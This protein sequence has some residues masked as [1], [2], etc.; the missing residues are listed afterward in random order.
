VTRF[1]MTWLEV[2]AQSPLGGNLHVVIHDADLLSGSTMQAAARR[3]RLSET[4][5]VCR[6]SLEGADYRHRI[7]TVT[8]ELPFA[9]HPS[10]GTAAAVAKRAG[11]GATSLVQETGYGLQR[12]D[13]SLAETGEDALVA[14]HQGQPNLLEEVTEVAPL[15]ES[16]GLDLQD[17]HPDLGPQVISTGLATLVAPVRD[18]ATLGRITPRLVELAAVL[19]GLESH[20]V[21]C[22]VVVMA[23]RYEAKNGPGAHW[24]ARC[25]TPAVASGEDSAT[26]SAAGPLTAYSETHLGTGSI[27]IEQGVEM[28]SPSRLYGRM[29]SGS[30]VV[31]GQARFVGQGW[32][33]LP[34]AR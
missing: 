16:L 8:S 23:E 26:G 5:F 30:V 3:F 11:N 21:T 6:P 9:G 7:F 31:S 33:D 14:L 19:S 13:V 15:L 2:F 17:A 20:P 1:E 12:L 32:I 24:N 22:Y 18:V 28:G 29:E 10:I 4:S 25:F 27:T 34:S